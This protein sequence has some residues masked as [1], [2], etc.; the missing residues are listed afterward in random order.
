MSDE[1]EVLPVV[2]GAPEVIWL[3]YGEIERDCTHDEAHSSGDGVLWSPHAIETSDVRYIRADIVS[4]DLAKADREHGYTKL[5]LEQAQ[6]N[7]KMADQCAHEREG[8]ILKLGR[9]IETVRAELA[10]AQAAVPRWSY[11]NRGEVPTMG[12]DVLCARAGMDGVEFLVY[13]AE[14]N[15]GPCLS[16]VWIDNVTQTIYPVADG[17]AWMSVPQPPTPLPET[18]KRN[19]T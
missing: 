7:Y 12:E 6:H 13:D 11:I 19:E 16:H 2:T 15:G 9:E 4:A 17:D 10:T 14:D 3:T 5:L 18:A 8:Q 1:N